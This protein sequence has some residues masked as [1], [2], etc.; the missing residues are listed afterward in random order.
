MKKK[1]LISTVLGSNDVKTGMKSAVKALGA[2]NPFTINT[3]GDVATTIVVQGGILIALS[4]KIISYFR[5][6]NSFI[7][8][9]SLSLY[10]DIFNYVFFN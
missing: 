4:N 8:F 9:V 3:A 5:I 2:N 10:S 1:N 7:L 6:L